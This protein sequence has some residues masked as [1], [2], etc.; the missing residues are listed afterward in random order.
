VHRSRQHSHPSLHPN[1][2]G[3]QPLERLRPDYDLLSLLGH[4]SGQQDRSIEIDL[5]YGPNL[6]IVL[7]GAILLHLLI[8]HLRL[9]IAIHAEQLLHLVLLHLVAARLLLAEC[10]SVG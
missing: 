8:Q 7:A 2:Y 5:K 3:T 6:A 1:L 9:L 10:R 4:S